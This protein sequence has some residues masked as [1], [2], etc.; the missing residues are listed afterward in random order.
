VAGARPA[1]P[2]QG[3]KHGALPKTITAIQPFL[4]LDEHL[5]H[6][7][8]WG[9]T[10]DFCINVLQPLLWKYPRQTLALLQQWNRSENPW[11]RRASVVVFTRKVGASGKFIR[12]DQFIS[13]PLTAKEWPDFVLLFEVHG[14]QYGCVYGHRVDF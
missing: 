1:T 11:K 10:D 9:P 12:K 3:V 7:R 2:T 5:N 14:L 6:F 8:G 13:K 4:D